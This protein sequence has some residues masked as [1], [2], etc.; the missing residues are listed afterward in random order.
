[1]LVLEHLL[2]RYE[3]IQYNFP[4]FFMQISPENFVVIPV[5][6]IFLQMKIACFNVH[7]D[8]EYSFDKSSKY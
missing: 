2:L 4:N 6:L 7:V 1:M 3:T 8:I 5:P